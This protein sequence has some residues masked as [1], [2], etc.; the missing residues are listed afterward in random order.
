MKKEKV[1]GDRE[2][3]RLKIFVT[4][5]IKYLGDALLDITMRAFLDR[6]EQ[7]H[8]L[9][10]SYLTMIDFSADLGVS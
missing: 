3:F 2:Q 10:R 9:C 1:I 6:K 4:T 5:I 8:L 7:L